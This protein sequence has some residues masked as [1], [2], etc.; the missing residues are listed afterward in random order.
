VRFR[1]CCD[2]VGRSSLRARARSH[3]RGPVS[4]AKQRLLQRCPSLRRVPCACPVPSARQAGF[5]SSHGVSK[6][7]SPPTLLCTVLSHLFPKSQVSA[8]PCRGDAP[9]ALAVFTTATVFSSAQCCCLA[10][11]PPVLRFAF[12]HIGYRYPLKTVL[13]L[14][15]TRSCRVHRLGSSGS[16]A[17]SSACPPERSP[18]REPP[19]CHHPGIPPH[20]YPP[21]SE[22]MTRLQNVPSF[23][24]RGRSHEVL[25]PRR[26]RFSAVLLAERVA[27]RC[28]PGLLKRLFADDRVN[29]FQLM[30]KLTVRGDIQASGKVLLVAPHRGDSLVRPHL[31]LVREAS[32]GVYLLSVPPS[33]S[34]DRVRRSGLLQLSAT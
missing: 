33:R 4:C 23:P 22:W 34:E 26:V 29:C 32:V 5:R 8:S 11:Q 27:G 6:N 2:L 10:R 21:T 3:R 18:L 13:L 28:S 9:S 30:S 24:R 14:G 7:A 31:P 12:P 1:L 19:V 17:W 25:S 20:R 16:R 15:A